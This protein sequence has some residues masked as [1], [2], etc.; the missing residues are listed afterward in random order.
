MDLADMAI[1]GKAIVSDNQVPDPATELGTNLAKKL[2]ERYALQ[3]AV[4]REKRPENALQRGRT[5]APKPVRPQADLVLEV[6]TTRWGMRRSPSGPG[7]SKVYYAASVKL[8]DGRGS[9]LVAGDCPRNPGGAEAVGA[10]EGSNEDTLAANATVLKGELQRQ[11]EFCEVDLSSR[12]FYLST[13]RPSAARP[14]PATAADDG[15][16]ASTPAATPSDQERDTE[17]PR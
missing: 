1:R 4:V 11:A 10:L 14:S 5:V 7:R 13:A 3:L 6:L 17:Q 16:A 2:A 9:V 8:S 12:L 15:A